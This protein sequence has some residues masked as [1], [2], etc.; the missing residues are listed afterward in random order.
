MAGG[1]GGGGGYKPMDD[2]K[3]TILYTSNTPTL[4]AGEERVQ[5]FHPHT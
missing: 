5:K 1:G 3:I 4:K 2:G